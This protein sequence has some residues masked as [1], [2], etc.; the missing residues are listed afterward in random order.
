MKG[1][2]FRLVSRM[3]SNCVDTAYMYM[4]DGSGSLVQLQIP[5]LV[6]EH[7]LHL[8]VSYNITS[9]YKTA[10]NFPLSLYSASPTSSLQCPPLSDLYE[11]M[12]V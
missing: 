9:Q 10:G 5:V 12:H 8:V 2:D 6:Y 7:F 1:W 3:E 4:N 11:H